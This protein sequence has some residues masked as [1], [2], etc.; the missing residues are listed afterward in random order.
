[1]SLVCVS[2]DLVF[3]LRPL[4]LAHASRVAPGSAKSKDQS[5][6]LLQTHFH[7]RVLVVQLR[8]LPQQFFCLLRNHFR[9]GHLHLNK[10]IAMRA[11]LAQGWR[12]ALAQAKFL[13]RLRARR[14]AQLRLAFHSRHFD[15]RSERS[16]RN[17]YRNSDVD[18]VALAREVFV[19]ADVGNDM[20]VARRC[21]EA[22]AFTLARNAHPRTRFHT[23]WDAHFHCLCF[24]YRAFAFAQR[25]GRS[26]ATGATA[27]GTF[28]RKAQ[29][30]AGALDLPR[31]FA[32][33]AD[34]HWPTDVSGA[35][36]T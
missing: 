7:S 10:L 2:F 29:A 25:A 1:M 14:Y 17:G 9:K 28:L 20:Q 27:V 26:P 21:A 5:P 34:H 11:G 4:V 31:A 13:S 16:F 12:A 18:I 36:A 22:S 8:I 15:L 19:R 23:G 24:W 35:V 30:A 32:S 6:S 3:G 33:L